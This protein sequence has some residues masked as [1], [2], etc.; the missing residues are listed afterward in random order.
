MRDDHDFVLSGSDAPAGADGAVLAGGLPDVRVPLRQGARFPISAEILG[1]LMQLPTGL[2]VRHITF[3]PVAQIAE[4]TVT[5]EAPGLPELAE[6]EVTPVI[7]PPMLEALGGVVF[8][9]GFRS[10]MRWHFDAAPQPSQ[11]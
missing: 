3:D 11:G 6:G 9:D 7:G 4:V 1:R 5:G 10:L 2:T 8:P